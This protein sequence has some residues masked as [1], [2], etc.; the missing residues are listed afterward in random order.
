MKQNKLFL[1]GRKIIETSVH[2]FLA[3]VILILGLYALVPIVET[4]LDTWADGSPASEVVYDVPPYASLSITGEKLKGLFFDFTTGS[5]QKETLPLSMIIDKPLE[6]LCLQKLQE[7]SEEFRQ[8]THRS[9]EGFYEIKNLGIGLWFFYTDGTSEPV[10]LGD[11]LKKASVSIR[12]KDL[13]I[14]AQNLI[15]EKSFY[16]YDDHST[17]NVVNVFFE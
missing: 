17:T 15:L 1:W 11:A 7:S 2:W 3:A 14:P 8:R 12:G 6:M 5:R 13:C 10:Y 16:D 9:V 4:I